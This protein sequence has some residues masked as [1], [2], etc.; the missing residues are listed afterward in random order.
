MSNYTNQYWIPPVVS[1]NIPIGS[2]TNLGFSYISDWVD[3]ARTSGVSFTFGIYVSSGSFDYYF[4]LEGSNQP[5]QSEANVGTAFVTPLIVVTGT[6][7]G[8]SGTFFDPT[9]VNIPNNF[10]QN[11]VLID[12][13]GEQFTIAFQVNGLLTVSPAADGT[14][15]PVT[16]AYSI[17]LTK[18]L[19]SLLS[20]YP[21]QTLQ[22]LQGPLNHPSISDPVALQT[23]AL[24]VAANGTYVL[25]AQQPCCRWVRATVQYISSGEAA[26]GSIQVLG[27]DTATSDFTG[28]TGVGT[29]ST[30]TD[31]GATFTTDGIQPGWTLV[32]S[33]GN[34]FKITAVT[35]QTVLAVTGTP[36]T[37]TGDYTISA[38]GIGDQ[39]SVE[40]VTLSAVASGTHTSTTFAIG[41]YTTT[42]TNLAAALAANT[43]ISTFVTGV[44]TSGT[45][46]LT[47]VN[48]G[49]P[50]NSI[51][52]QTT[53]VDAFTITPMS[54]GSDV[55]NGALMGTYYTSP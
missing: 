51:V 52:V 31:A 12:S 54:G 4:A 48:A 26:T 1:Q 44:D 23:L 22:G 15:T 30:W 29:L 34:G 33:A 55:S 13:A 32:D 17:A 14:T 9:L 5:P 37:G 28:T 7:I 24:P 38:V 8:G 16:G 41:S 3:L 43:A 11:F 18:W 2:N 6:G 35:S 40:G 46:A 19:P 20:V 21:L 49:A 53:D 10:Y 42:A 27:S 47:A 45:I 36:V 25:T 50:S 39:V